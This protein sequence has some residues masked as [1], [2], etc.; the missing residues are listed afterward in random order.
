MFSLLAHQS[1]KH[2]GDRATDDKESGQCCIWAEKLVCLPVELQAAA[3]FIREQGER[4]V[5]H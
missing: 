2:P 5:V 3:V 4:G 1:I